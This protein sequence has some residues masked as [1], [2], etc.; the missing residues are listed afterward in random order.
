MAYKTDKYKDAGVTQFTWSSSH[1]RRVRPDHAALDGQIF[2][3]DHPPI[4]NRAT[5]ARNLPGQDY[6]PCRCQDIPYTGAE[7]EKKWRRIA[8]VTRGQADARQ[9]RRAEAEGW[10]I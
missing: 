7:W 5:G 1:D 6:G 3:Y 10:R 4:T 2:D 9:V 8:E